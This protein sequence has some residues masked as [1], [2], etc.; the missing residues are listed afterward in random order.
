MMQPFLL[1]KN[2]P[3][4]V[5][6]LNRPEILNAFS[7]AHLA[8]LRELLREAEQDASI[9]AVVLTGAGRG[10]SS[11]GD[12]SSIDD[13]LQKA[14]PLDIVM[15]QSAGIETVHALRNSRLPIVAAVHGVAYGAGFA[16]ALACDLVVATRDARLCMVFSRLGISADMGAA[17][18]LTRTVGSHRAKELILLADEISGVQGVDLGIVNRLVDSP[19]EMMAVAI[20]LATRLASVP[21]AAT[22]MSKNLIN[23]SESL[24]LDDFFSLEQHASVVTITEAARSLSAAMKRP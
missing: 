7:G 18:L 17:W 16:L 4:A 13:L 10:F 21:S 14:G 3:I 19:E 9:R 2:G 11:G 6:T 1:E 5:I 12:R 8:R 20:D 23:R 24:A 15:T 22:A